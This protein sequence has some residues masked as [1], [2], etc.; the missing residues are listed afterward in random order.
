[1][2]WHFGY[3]GYYREWHPKNS[4]PFVPKP[5]GTSGQDGIFRFT[6]KKREID[7]NPLGMWDRPWCNIL[8]VAA[9]KGYG[10]A[11]A[12][13]SSLEDR[14]LT[15]RLAKDDV[16]IKGRVVDLQGR[17]VAGVRVWVERVTVGG[18][19][20]RSLW[21]PTWTGLPTN[22]TTAKDG[23]FTLTGIGRDR[24]VVLHFEGPTIE[25]KI[26]SANTQAVVEGKPV[27][28][29][30]IE[31]VAG[32]TKPIEGTIRAKDSGKPLPGVVVY[33]GDESDHSIG[34]ET[35]HRGIRAVT[36]KQGRYRVPG[37]P[38]AGTY[39][40]TV[41]PPVGQGYLWT[42]KH[43]GDSEG[44]RPI[45]ADIELRRGVEVRCRL[46]DKQTRQPVRGQLHYTPVK[47]NLYYSEAERVA[48]LYPTREF[49]RLHVPDADGV[50]H[51]VA[52]PGPGLLV[53][54]LQGNF[55]KYLPPRLDP[56]DR[57]KAQD[58]FHLRHVEAGLPYR[59]I[60]PKESKKPLVLDIELDPGRATK[61]SLIGPDGKPVTRA[62][63]YGLNHHPRFPTTM[64]QLLEGD[65][66][67][68]TLLESQRPRTVSFV[69]QDRKL[70][71]HMILR[72]DEKA[73]VVVRLQP[74]GVCTGRLVN[75]EGKPLSGVRLAWHYRSLPVPGMRP[76]DQ[77]FTTD[78]KGGFRVEGL[79]PGPTFELTLAGVNE[80]GVTLSAGEALKKLSTQAGETKDLGDITVQVV[81]TKKNEKGAKNE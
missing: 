41:Y 77:A 60:D 10:P 66:F 55:P 29:A 28:S 59:L 19:E 49:G 51:L 44:L 39:D 38:K 62:T 63:A 26:L 71:G 54:N 21:Q 53:A 80:K 52:Y 33:G 20:F 76:P 72:G 24:T 81:P 43:V 64:N 8:V 1:M 4:K 32:P 78:A 37:L 30:R 73:P 65:T 69:H 14:E 50:F 13:L 74:W 23:R 79:L 5:T 3:Y 27:P 17:P 22:V 45:T 75:A 57:E 34:H 12:S 70:A 42:V 46:I 9:A 7:E 2:W 36:D 35:Y 25:H 40:L 47:T 67:T 6:F 31:V 11:W 15:L 56:A 68:A 48:D 16:P 61:G 18:D 58:D